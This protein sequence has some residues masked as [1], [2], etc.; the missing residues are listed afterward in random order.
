MPSTG[1]ILSLVLFCGGLI[2]VAIVL[3]RYRDRLNQQ[4]GTG[5]I[6]IKGM[7]NMGGGARLCVVEVEGETFLCGLGRHSVSAITP[8]QAKSK[9]AVE[10]PS[11]KG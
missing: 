6:T 5:P 4:F 8:L 2:A 11:T 1:N 9:G 10:C 3:A 7:A